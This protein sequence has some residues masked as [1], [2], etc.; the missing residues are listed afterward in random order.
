MEYPLAAAIASLRLSATHFLNIER[1]RRIDPSQ[2]PERSD[3][4]CVLCV[5]EVEDEQHAL[6]KCPL[7]DDERGKW[8]G[9]LARTE[10][11]LQITTI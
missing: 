11:V 7:F 1:M 8:R 3:R 10:S 4:R 5:N 9:R 2:R 6:V